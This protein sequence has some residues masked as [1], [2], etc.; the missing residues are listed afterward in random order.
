MG[1]RIDKGKGQVFEFGSKAITADRARQ[2]RI[3]FERFAG[4]ALAL[5][6]R[7]EMQGAHI[8]QPVGQLD[9][10]DADIF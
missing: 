4:D 6:R 9:Q 7:H 3:D 10:Q 2:G 5:F 1:Q 8:V